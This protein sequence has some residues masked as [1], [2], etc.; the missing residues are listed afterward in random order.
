MNYKQPYPQQV[1]Y[2]S[3]LEQAQM[4]Q[5]GAGGMP[6]QPTQEYE[7]TDSIERYGYIIKDL[8]DTEKIVDAFELRLLGKKLT[9]E[10][11]IIKDETQD[12]KITKP[13]VARE[14]VDIVRAVV[15]RHNDF[16]YY[17]EKEAYM[18]IFGANYTMNRWLM[19]Q[20]DDIP[21]RYRSKIAFEGMSLISASLHK[22]MNGRMLVWT[23]GTFSEGRNMNPN[24][25]QEKSGLMD[26]IFPWMKRKA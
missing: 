24:G 2:I 3:P 6:Q 1:E 18:V 14:F 12:P 8:T 5:L 4:Q 17:D 22:A 21:L 26:Y 13:S 20:A 7:F 9:P 25:A 19:M 23:K 10:G 11:K 16:S 15:N